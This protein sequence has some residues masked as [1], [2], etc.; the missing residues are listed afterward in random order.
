MSVSSKYL[1]NFMIINKLNRNKNGKNHSCVINFY[2][3]INS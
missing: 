3:L 1:H 2:W